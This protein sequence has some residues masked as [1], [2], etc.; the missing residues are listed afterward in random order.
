[1]E[2]LGKHNRLQ[3]SSAP[4]ELEMTYEF[5][6]D[7][8]SRGLFQAE[9][10]FGWVGGLSGLNQKMKIPGDADKSGELEIQSARNSPNTWIKHIF[11]RSESKMRAQWSVLAV[12]K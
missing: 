8:F 2:G 9:H 3:P 10:D 11:N 5:P 12:R 4:G 6:E 1:M 7:G